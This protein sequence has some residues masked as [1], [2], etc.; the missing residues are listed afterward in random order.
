MVYL[1]VSIDTECDKGPGWLIQRP[2]SFKNIT[3]GLEKTL[4]PLFRKYSVKPTYLLSP[5]VLIHDPA[6]ELLKAMDQ[7]ELGTHL[8]EEFISPYVN[9]EANRTKNV[10]CDLTSVVEENKLEN[11]TNLFVDRFGYPPLAFRAGR[12]GMSQHTLGI[13]SK[14][15]YKVDSSITPFKSHYYESGALNNFWG[16]QPY[17]YRIKETQMLEVPVTIINP[18]IAWLPS[19]FQK[20]LGRKNA[21]SKRILKRMGVWGESRWLRPW[22]SS[23]DE[24]AGISEYLIAHAGRRPRVLNMMFHSNEI[25]PG[26]SPYCQTQQEV[27]SFVDTLDRYFDFLFSNYDVCSTGLGEYASYF[28]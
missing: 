20:D 18:S 17:P 10:Q 24:L 5:E 15:K 16:H 12:F 26:A 7:V 19:F 1:V 22:R 3:G 9:W 11:L 21:L 28:K 27:D 4:S 13:L 8:H 2:M 14:L 6:V 25:E 23:A